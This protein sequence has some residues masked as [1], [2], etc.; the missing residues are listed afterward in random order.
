[1]GFAALFAWVFMIKTRNLFKYVMWSRYRT[2]NNPD[3]IE[4]VHNKNQ[5]RPLRIPLIN[6]K[7]V[8]LFE[9]LEA[10]IAACEKIYTSD[11]H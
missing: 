11:N 10:R 4:V 8:R 1:M 2:E 3:A 7:G 5:K 9:E 6:N